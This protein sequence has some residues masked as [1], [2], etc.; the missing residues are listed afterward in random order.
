MRHIHMKASSISRGS[1]NRESGF[2]LI[3]I[4]VSIVVF[5]I[6]LLGAA[7]LQLA[8][9]RSNQFTAQASVATQLIRDYEEITQMLRSAD[10]STSEG[11]NVLSSLD[12]NTADTTTVTCQSSAPH[13]RPASWRHSCLRSGK[14]ASLQSFQGGEP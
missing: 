10:L 5:G 9:M 8:T 11:S 1:V 4:L 12:T 3:E 14:A 6:G 7:G 2:S 13:A